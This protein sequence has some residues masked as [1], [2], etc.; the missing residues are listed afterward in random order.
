MK[1]NMTVVLIALHFS[2]IQKEVTDHKSLMH[3]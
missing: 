1:F 2:W 3:I